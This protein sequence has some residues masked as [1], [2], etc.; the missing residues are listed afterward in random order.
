M[1]VLDTIIEFF[2]YRMQT[3]PHLVIEKETKLIDVIE[4]L[5]IIKILIIV[6]LSSSLF[7]SI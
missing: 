2:A 6:R 3:Y 5:K 7:N 4:I 1:T